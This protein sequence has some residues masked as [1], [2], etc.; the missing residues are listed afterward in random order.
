MAAAADAGRDGSRYACTW[1]GMV[2]PCYPSGL[3]IPRS[4]MQNIRSSG[5]H[6][7]DAKETGL[8]AC[9]M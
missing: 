9:L 5:T 1:S 3:R 6:S 7:A 8:R 2:A 4:I